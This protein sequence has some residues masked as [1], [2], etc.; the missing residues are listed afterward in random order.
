VPI[1]STGEPDAL[2]AAHTFGD[3]HVEPPRGPV[4]LHGKRLAR[5]RVCLFQRHGNRRFCPRTPAL[6]AE[7]FVHSG[8]AARSCGTGLRAEELLEEVAEPQ[9]AE[10]ILEAFSAEGH[11]P[12]TGRLSCA[13]AERLLPVHPAVL[14]RVKHLVVSR[15]AVGIAQDLV[16]LVH[17]LELFFRPRGLIHVGVVLARQFP[18]GGA[19]RL[20]ISRSIHAQDFVV[21]FEFHPLFRDSHLGVAQ[22][23]AITKY[24]RCISFTIVP[25]STPASTDATTSTASWYR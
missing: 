21:V 23:V 1:H 3:G 9:P 24:P 15:A 6:P 13:L 17:F 16:G 19:D 10:Q 5:T 7:Q 14:I 8:P 12:P 25:G 20:L 11:G 22:H 4:E 2:A 18:V